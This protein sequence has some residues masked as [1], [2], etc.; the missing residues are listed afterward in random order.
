MAESIARTARDSQQRVAACKQVQPMGLYEAGSAPPSTAFVRSFSIFSW[1]PSSA[2]SH[3]GHSRVS[4]STRQHAA[5]CGSS[6][7]V[8][9]DDS[10]TM[11]GVRPA[12]LAFDLRLSCFLSSF[13]RIEMRLPP[14]R[15]SRC[16]SV[17]PGP[18][19]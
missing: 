6:E 13:S 10:A 15:A 19:P 3:V 18:S 5:L 12:A 16:A 14:N 11:H 2:R 8:M 17:E 7:E 4:S 9:R 1:R